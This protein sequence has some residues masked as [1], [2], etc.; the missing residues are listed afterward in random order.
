M[1]IKNNC[2]TKKNRALLLKA[3]GFLYNGLIFTFPHNTSEYE[4]AVLPK[5]SLSSGLTVN[6]AG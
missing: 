5:K 6:R 4:Y 2:N 3:R 1:V